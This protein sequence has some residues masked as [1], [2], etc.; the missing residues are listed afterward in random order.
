MADDEKKLQP[1]TALTNNDAAGV[2]GPDGCK[3]ADHR[4]KEKEKQVD[5]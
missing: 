3:I 5:K 1:L 2:C 4:Q